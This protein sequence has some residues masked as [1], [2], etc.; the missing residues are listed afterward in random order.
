MIL[1]W[2]FMEWVVAYLPYSPTKHSHWMV[3]LTRYNDL[4]L[5]SLVI[6]NTYPQQFPT[7]SIFKSRL[8]RGVV[9]KIQWNQTLHPGK[10]AGALVMNEGHSYGMVTT[11]SMDLV[12][13]DHTLHEYFFWP[14]ATYPG[15]KYGIFPTLQRI[16]DF[17]DWSYH[18]FYYILLYIIIIIC[19]YIYIYIHIFYH[20]WS[21]M[22]I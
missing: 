7:C 13:V 21:Y 1:N 17:L 22:Y 20:I 10:N 2:R 19:I 15:V 9:A 14:G 18:M 6:T 5:Q 4:F 12:F 11:K 8:D 16:P 3:V